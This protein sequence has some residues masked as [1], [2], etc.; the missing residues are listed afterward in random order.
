MIANAFGPT[1]PTVL[2]ADFRL[3]ADLRDRPGV[4]SGTVPIGTAFPHLDAVLLD[5]NGRPGRRG[6]VRARSAAAAN[7]PGEEGPT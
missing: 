2:C 6:T 7:L 1:E 4:S 5:E 3:S